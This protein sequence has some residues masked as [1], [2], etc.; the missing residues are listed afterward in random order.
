MPSFSEAI[1]DE[2][3]TGSP[4]DAY[5]SKIH[6]NIAELENIMEYPRSYFESKVLPTFISHCIQFETFYFSI[7]L[8]VIC[9]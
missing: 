3:G 5:I 9:R 7:N 8:T 6:E 2:E 4:R 1:S